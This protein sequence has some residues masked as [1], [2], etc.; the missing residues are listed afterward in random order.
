MLRRRNGRRFPLVVIG[1]L[2]FSM[3]MVGGGTAQAA[4][5]SR[6]AVPGVAP[7]P[8]ANDAGSIAEGD[9]QARMAAEA[10]TRDEAIRRY[11]VEDAASILQAQVE[12]RWPDTHAGVWIDRLPFG[13][14]VAFTENAEANVASLRQSFPFP[15]DLSAVTLPRSLASLMSLQERMRADRQALA[16]DAPSTLP[17]PIQD[18]E[19][20]YDLDIDVRA[21]MAVVR[22]EVPTPALQEAFEE[23]YS[24]AVVV[25]PGLAQP[26]VCTQL[27]CRWAMLGGLKFEIPNTGGGYCSSGFSAINGGVHFTLSAGH[28]RIN[29]GV[30]A[31]DHAGARYGSVDAYQWS[32]PVDAERV[33]R[34]STQF[35]NSGK[36]IVQGEEDPRL[37]SGFQSYSGIVIGTYIGKTGATSGTTRGY[38]LSK[39]ASPNFGDGVDR[40][41]Y[42]TS[43]MCVD[44]GDSGGSVWRSYTA[45]GLVSGLSLIGP[46]CTTYISQISY[47]LNAMNVSL[48][49]NYNLLPTARYTHTCTLTHCVFD[50][51]SSTDYDG[52][53]YLYYWDFGDGGS[54][55]PV[56]S[57][58]FT[59]P[60][61]KTVTLTVW[62]NDGELDTSTKNIQVVVP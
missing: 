10:I 7:E 62:D 53:I 33:D 25:K 46:G 1:S 47:I 61:T 2:L 55:D 38:V 48:L 43:D 23:T 34:T 35:R 40:Y 52:H 15:D 11:H 56:A 12:S 57:H 20:R 27:D 41:N 50:G 36:F 26:A 58:I 13:V 31:R 30:A 42:V 37:V 54:N 19:G 8:T 29:S 60:G 24:S 45:W 22:V 6:P 3:S 5:D 4:I 16:Q 49:T 39:T 44:Y 59:A 21:N 17:Q 9:I 51:T 18:T 32:G 28:C 14:H